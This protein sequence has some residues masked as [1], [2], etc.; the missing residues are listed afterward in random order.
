M[1][2]IY[3]IPA[4]TID[5]EAASLRD[6]EGKVML[7]VNVA[8]KCGLTPQYESLQRLYDQRKDDGF[9][10]V[11]FPCNDFGAQE[12]GTPEEIVTFCSTTYNVDF[13]LMEK[14]A[15]KGAAQH[16]I[17]HALIEAQ[18]VATEKPGSDFEEKLAG[19]GI[20]KD[21]PTDIMWNFE[22]FLIARDGTIKARFAPDVAVDEEPLASAI[23]REL[24]AR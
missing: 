16:P 6:Y 22:K 21:G 19:Y 1:N 13:P 24:A 20:K 18:P 10:I 15:V 9:V 4:K 7:V 8:S 12:P 5:G 23:D 17:Y 2:T 11:G 14:V 3:D